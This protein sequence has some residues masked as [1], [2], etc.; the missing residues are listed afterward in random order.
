M[1]KYPEKPKRN[2]HRI[3]QIMANHMPTNLI[4]TKNMTYHQRDEKHNTKPMMQRVTNSRQYLNET[5][6]GTKMKLSTYC[7]DYKKA[8]DLAL[9]SWLAEM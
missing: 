7:I 3:R 1:E 5:C 6:Y 2:I 8:F 4:Q 9:R